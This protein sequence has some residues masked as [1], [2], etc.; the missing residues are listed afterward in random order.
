MPH[1]EQP[2]PDDQEE[3]QP[4]R[5]ELDPH[6]PAGH[7]AFDH[8]ILIFR[9]DVSRQR[10]VFDRKDHREVLDPDLTRL[11]IVPGAIDRDHAGREQR[12][13]DL[14][15]FDGDPFEVAVGDL[16]VEFRVSNAVFRR[17]AHFE[18]LKRDEQ[19]QDEDHPEHHGLERRLTQTGLVQGRATFAVSVVV[20][21]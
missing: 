11:A 13:V 17:L 4:R 18:H 3:R 2:Q 1:D 12:T 6:A 10:R 15:P 20:H 19:D 5:E 7:L 21:N 16:F 8:C 9:K 14:E